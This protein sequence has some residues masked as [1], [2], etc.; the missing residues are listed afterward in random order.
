MIILVETSERQNER[1]FIN[2]FPRWAVSYTA[3]DDGHWKK[4]NI[5]PTWRNILC[6]L[7]FDTPDLHT[8]ITI[9]PKTNFPINLEIK[10]T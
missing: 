4:E 9:S 10:M 1:S 5:R 6:K 3:L 2:G 7:E 8:N